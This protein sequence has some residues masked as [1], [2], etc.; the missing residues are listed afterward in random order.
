MQKGLRSRFAARGH[1]APPDYEGTV[2]DFYRYL[3]GRL[4]DAS[5][6]SR[7]APSRAGT[8]SAAATTA[9]GS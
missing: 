3:A 5:S 2:L 1:L 4:D 6:S 7:P 8:R 9:P